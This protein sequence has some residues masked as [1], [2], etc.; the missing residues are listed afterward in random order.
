MPVEF[1]TH[2]QKEKYGKYSDEPS[3][4][5]LAKYFW[6]DDK[7]INRIFSHRHEYN[8]LGFALQ[9]GTV[10]F[11][12]TFL[13]EPAKIPT[14]IISYVSQQLKIRSDVYFLYIS[15]KNI[16]NHRNEIRKFYGYN[17]FSDQPFHFKFIRWL[18]TRA[19]VSAERPS[20]LF[21]LATARCIENKILLPGVT[22]MERL[23]SQI[24]DRSNARLWIK[25][26]C[27]PNEKQISLLEKLLITQP[28]NRNTTLDILRQ[29][30][31]KA[32]SN[33]LLSAI[34]RLEELRKLGAN[35][36]NISTIPMGRIKILARYAS[37][38]RA[39][40]IARM[41]Y[42]RCIATLVSFAIVFTISAS[43]VDLNIRGIM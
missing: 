42:S 43:Y 21:D 2:E 3:T 32:T 23:I 37:M 41:S 25:L 4:E 40:T 9:L 19:W 39:Q 17:D 33:G 27:L 28:K 12:G 8:R 24:R 30:P 36:W 14:S 7:D 15:T 6:F 34:Y 35:K 10:R 31:K 38:A 5:Q 29:P 16:Q 13:S 1:L 11:L 26:G 22:V 20:V 18:Y